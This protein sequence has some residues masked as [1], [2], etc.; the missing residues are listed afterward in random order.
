MHEVMFD[1]YYHI[2]V[3]DSILLLK[4]GL[5]WIHSQSLMSYWDGKDWCSNIYTKIE[6]P[7]TNK[8]NEIQN[9]KIS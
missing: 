9:W 1:I 3:L 7:Y 5:V 4:I 6:I 8:W 2:I